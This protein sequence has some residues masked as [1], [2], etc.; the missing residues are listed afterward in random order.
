[1]I[2]Y[3]AI[4]D[5]AERAGCK[6]ASN[7]WEST[8]EYFLPAGYSFSKPAV[9][10]NSSQMIFD[11]MMDIVKRFQ[12]FIYFDS[13]GKL[14]I[15]KLDGGL[16]SSTSAASGANF[17]S[18]ITNEDSMILEEKQV[19][20]NYDSTVNVISAITL[21]RDTRNLVMYT[22]TATGSESNLLFKKAALINQAALGELEV[23]RNWVN[24]AAD[25]M[26][27]PILK[28]RWKTAG[29]NVNLKPL[30]FAEVDGQTF[31]IT[32]LKRSYNAENNDLTVNYE[33]EWLGGK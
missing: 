4:L 10:Y 29:T 16:F 2:A 22:R 28:A 27:Y 17:S 12:A 25:R 20:V 11:C 19:E 31:R 33:G 21:E 1:M 26:F 9:R 14:V 3:Y 13:Q 15:S 32:S 23:C 8:N 18:G 24:D 5:M 7:D 30:E 6:N